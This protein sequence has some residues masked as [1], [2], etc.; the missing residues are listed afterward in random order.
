[1]H[2]N[3]KENKMIKVE[4]S[5]PVVIKCSSSEDTAFLDEVIRRALSQKYDRMFSPWQ[6]QHHSFDDKFYRQ[7]VSLLEDL[8]K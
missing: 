5:Y 6:D 4:R 3:K 7:A 2:W 1:M 8:N